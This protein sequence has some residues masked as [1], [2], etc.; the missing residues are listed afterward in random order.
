MRERKSFVCSAAKMGGPAA[1][2]GSKKPHPEVGVA[3]AATEARFSSV[4]Q[5]VS[6]R[7]GLQ[8]DNFHPV[9]FTVDDIE[10][11]SAENYFQ[12]QKSA[13][14]SEVRTTRV[15]EEGRN[16]PYDFSGVRWRQ[17]LFPPD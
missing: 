14:V 16:A 1:I 15:E 6:H 17:V 8:T 10:Y 3:R 13:G 11:Y 9:K 4:S 12:C 5:N 7:W 2:K